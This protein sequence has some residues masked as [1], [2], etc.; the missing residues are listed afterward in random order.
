MD[1]QEDPTWM[2][3]SRAFIAHFRQTNVT[4]AWLDEIRNLK[5]GEGGV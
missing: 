3:F 2:E 5:V 4:A 1:Q